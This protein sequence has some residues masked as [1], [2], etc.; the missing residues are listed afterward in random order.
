MK[1]LLWNVSRNFVLER[2]SFQNFV[3]KIHA[4]FWENN[5]VKLFHSLIPR[6]IT[7][8]PAKFFKLWPEK[9]GDSE[10]IKNWFFLVN[11]GFFEMILGF[12]FLKSF[13]GGKNQTFLIICP[14]L[15][16]SLVSSK[17]SV[18]AG[19]SLQTIH[20]LFTALLI[21]SESTSWFF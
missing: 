17:K 5:L 14:L 11:T 8:I 13:N 7:N 10:W 12:S 15:K 6:Y 4:I 16:T 21:S 20:L 3:Q 19:I 1:P 9:C 2:Y 18:W